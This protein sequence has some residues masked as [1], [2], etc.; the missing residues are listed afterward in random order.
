MSKFTPLYDNVLVR[1]AKNENTTAGGIIV[2]ETSQ[3]KTQT[4]EVLAVGQG[5]LNN[6]GSV[7]ALSVQV[8][9]KVIFGKYSGSEIELDGAELLV[10]KEHEI[11]GIIQQ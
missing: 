8:G 10:L 6:D 3:S 5:K 11:L 4:G 1:R 2:P 9:N 7:K